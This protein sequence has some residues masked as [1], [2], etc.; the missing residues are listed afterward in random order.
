MRPLS[1]DP[2]TL[3]FL[4]DPNSIHTRRWIEFFARSGHAVHLLVLGE[5]PVRPGLDERIRVWR[6][7]SYQGSPLPIGMARARASL[8]ARLAAIRPDV[9]HGHYLTTYGWLARLAGF[10]PYVVT[11][12]GSDVYVTARESLR[13]RLWARFA[14][15]G[16]DLVTADSA[17]LGRSAVAVGARAD[18]M[19]IVQFGVDT[20]RFAPGPDPVELRARLGLSQ[21]RVIFS[22]RVVAPPYRHDMAIEAIARLP[23]DTTLLMTAEG[24]DAAELERLMGRITQLNI[25]DRVV[26]SPGIEHEAMVQYLRLADVVLSVP[27]TDATP[28]TL[29]EA[30]AVGR[31]IVATDLP[32][33]REWLAG[34]PGA[35]LVPVGSVEATTEAIAKS[36]GR[37]EEERAANGARL[38]DIVLARADQRLAM[39][40]MES[41]YRAL[42][43][44]R[45]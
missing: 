24:A 44:R 2:L 4:G 8:R 35:S 21:R 18:R 38:R 20:A 7:D 31:P 15:G 41:A 17:D 3:A 28:V 43:A 16:A 5:H 45:H 37:P 34:V 30:M 25:A 29:L 36:L 6:Y 1:F 33:V 22:A 9:L 39:A 23:T 19:R 14:L 42:T 10:H 32:S 11:V 40:D 13:S 26:I 27:A 12:W